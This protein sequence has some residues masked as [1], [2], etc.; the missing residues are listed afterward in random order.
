M[1]VYHLLAEDLGA[2]RP[3]SLVRLYLDVKEWLLNW[4]WKKVYFLILWY[5]KKW[6]KWQRVLFGRGRLCY[7]FTL[8][9]DITY[10]NVLWQGYRNVAVGNIF[11]FFLLVLHTAAETPARVWVW[12]LLKANIKVD[13]VSLL[14][15]FILKSG[16]KVVAVNFGAGLVECQSTVITS[17]GSQDVL[18][19]IQIWANVF[20]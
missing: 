11:F 16:F 6:D 9:F 12:S 8:T 14:E 17:C 13:R 18:V 3:V 10:N 19:Q 1:L 2:L 5:D 4:G 20:V 7:C 15:I